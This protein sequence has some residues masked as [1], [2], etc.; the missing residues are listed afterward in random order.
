[1]LKKRIGI[2][3]YHKFYNC[4]SMLQAYA[5]QKYLEMQ[6]F[7]SEIINYI[8][9]DNSESK[10][11]ILINRIKRILIPEKR[12]TMVFKARN[13]KLM[14]E[15]K[16]SFDK[17]YDK[18]IKLSKEKYSTEKELRENLPIYDIYAVGSDQMWNPYVK[19]RSN[20]FYLS[21]VPDEMKKI[22]YAPS[23]GGNFI[24]KEKQENMKKYLEKF[25]Y[26][27]C[28]DEK[29]C[30]ILSKLLNR[31]VEHVV[32]PTLLL[33]KEEWSKIGCPVDGIDREYILCYFLGNKKENIKFANELGKRTN[34]KVYYI[35]TLANDI[36]DENNYLF[37][38][39]PQEFIWLIK[40]AQCICTDSFHGTIFSMNFKKDFYSFTKRKDGEGSDNNRIYG[41]LKEFGLENRLI[42]DKNNR[43]INEIEPID[44]SKI[45][46]ILNKEI[47]KSKEYLVEATR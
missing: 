23:I 44:Y 22:S 31:K 36:I 3:T 34:K 17:F 11:Q 46:P 40:N 37:N 14:Q 6:N 25:D 30:E 10:I 38:V 29:G 27:S 19:I 43:E 18:Y 12:K 5:L 13:S 20:A 4:G 41:I 24:A 2:I 15:H 8:I 39:G 33:D 47:Q 21:F 45:N 1:M 32:D 35:Y 28:R 7:D 26:L 42:N 9:A 16:K